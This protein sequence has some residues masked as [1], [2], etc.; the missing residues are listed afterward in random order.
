VPASVATSANTT[1]ARL[2]AESREGGVRERFVREVLTHVPLARVAELHL[3]APMRQGGVEGGVAVIAAVSA[4]DPTDPPRHTVYTARYRLTVRGPDRGRWQ[5][6]V[7]AEADA[8]L[9]TVDAV[10]R[11]VQRRAGDASPP[12]RLDADAVERLVGAIGAMMPAQP[13]AVA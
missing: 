4:E 3:F 5:V 6:D 2:A 8:P 11:G 10:V 12:V 9:V 7:R 1:G 13:E